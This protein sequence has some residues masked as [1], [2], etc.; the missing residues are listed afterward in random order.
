MKIIERL[1]KEQVKGD[2]PEFRIGDTL[3]VHL[4]IIEDDRERIQVFTGVCIAR[5][6]SGARESITLRRVASG[7]GVEKVFLIHSPR[8][9]RIEVGRG[10]AVRRAKLYYLRGKKGKKARLRERRSA[11]LISEAEDRTAPSDE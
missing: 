1:E 9:A 4:K 11:P 6:G 2:L 10:G 7:L 8:I 3:S 5:K